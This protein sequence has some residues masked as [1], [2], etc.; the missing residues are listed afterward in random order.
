MTMFQV[1]DLVKFANPLP[2]ETGLVMRVL[3]VNGDRLLVEY[4]VNMVILPTGI[5]NTNDV[6]KL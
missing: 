1:N 3:E 6:V 5:V 4:R 2:E